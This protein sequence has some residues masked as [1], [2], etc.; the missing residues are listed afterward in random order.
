MS[1]FNRMG[2]RFR[3]ARVLQSMESAGASWSLVTKYAA[4]QGVSW[5]VERRLAESDAEYAKYKEWCMAQGL[6]NHEYVVNFTPWEASGFA[7]TPNLA[8]YHTAPQISHWVVWHHPDRM[9]GDTDLVQ[10]D[11]LE[12]VRDL[13]AADMAS[14][15]GHG[16]ASS[17]ELR[18][19][20]PRPDELALF[21]NTPDMRSIETI[22]HSHCFFKPLDD[23][24]GAR[25]AGALAR[26]R[27]RWEEMSPWLKQQCADRAE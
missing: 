18:A 27:A 15:V 6:D 20:V 14:T 22:A 3:C 23:A 5:G 19:W 21:Q 24:A 1:L 8:P 9:P 4:E 10:A 13:L 16:A 2:I 7:L 17:E 11:E 25:L 26:R 12:L